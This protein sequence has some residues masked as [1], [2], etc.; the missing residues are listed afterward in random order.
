MHAERDQRG[1]DVLVGGE[2]GD[3]VEGLEDE[4]ERA[5]PHLADP[6]F[7]RGGQVLPGEADPA[8][9]R[10]VQAAQQLEQRGLAVPGLALDGEPLPRP[11]VQVELADGED[12]AAALA[13][14]LADPGQLVDVVA[15]A[16]P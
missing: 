11:D 4:A 15:G 7:W 6:G 12:L 14:G 3:Q 13:V 1:L 8:P 10:P 16:M 5:R 9:G 2:R